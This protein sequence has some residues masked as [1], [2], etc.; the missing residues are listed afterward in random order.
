[1]EWMRVGQRERE[2]PESSMCVTVHVSWTQMALMTLCP[3]E[4][5]PGP[6]VLGIKD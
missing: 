3:E 4:N 5:V 2:E 1:M 6:M